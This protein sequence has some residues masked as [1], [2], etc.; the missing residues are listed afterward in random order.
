MRKQRE[1]NIVDFRNPKEYLEVICD[2]NKV[3]AVLTPANK[4]QAPKRYTCAQAE[5]GKTFLRASNL[6]IHERT[7]FGLKP[8]QCKFGQCTFASERKETVVQHVRITHFNLPRSLREQK[9]KNIV[10]SRNPDDYIEVITEQFDDPNTRA[11]LAAM[12]AANQ[13]ARTPTVAKASTPKIITAKPPILSRSHIATANVI[14]PPSILYPPHALNPSN[15]PAL[16]QSQLQQQAQQQQPLHSQKI[17]P[18][19]RSRAKSK[20]ENKKPPPAHMC[21]HPGCGKVFR[22]PA[23]LKDHERIHLGIKPFTCAF[24]QCNFSSGR[25]ENV[26][27]HIR[28]SHFH[29][30]RSKKEQNAKNI[31]DYR[32]PTEYVEIDRALLNRA[33]AIE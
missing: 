28:T 6:K 31:E 11:Q 23:N 14:Y 25:K 12:A 21:Q 18:V 17:I 22:R 24:G 9:E 13:A 32:D 30:P 8:F 2:P 27:Q 19:T 33:D 10:E 3:Y 16:L 1:K 5:C 15:K 20:A 7:H 26:I 29:L 4:S